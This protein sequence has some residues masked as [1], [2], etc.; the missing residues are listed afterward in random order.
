M[1]NFYT[2]T[3]KLKTILTQLKQQKVHD[4]DLA[5]Y[6]GV[7]PANFASMKRRNAIPFRAVLDFCMKHHINANTLLF[8]QPVNNIIYTKPLI[9]K[10]TKKC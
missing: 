1:N 3:V 2:I 5:Q 7:S 10:Y 6:L 8:N 4:K 9:L